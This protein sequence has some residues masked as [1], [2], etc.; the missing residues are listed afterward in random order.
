MGDDRSRLFYSA[1]GIDVSV[2]AGKVKLAC[3]LPDF[4]SAE[5]VGPRGI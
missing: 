3:P 4:L 2:D 1:L 5:E